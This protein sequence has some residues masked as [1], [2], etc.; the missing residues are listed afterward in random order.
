MTNLGL[1]LSNCKKGRINI[2]KKKI[3]TLT[4]LLWQTKYFI[5]EKSSHNVANV[6]LR[7]AVVCPIHTLL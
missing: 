6:I 1:A 5:C 7:F 3:S 4:T 2:K